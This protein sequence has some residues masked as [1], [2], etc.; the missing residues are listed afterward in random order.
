MPKAE[1]WRAGFG[2][3]KDIKRVG[4]RPKGNSAMRLA[5]QRH[6]FALSKPISIKERE[7][8]TIY[9]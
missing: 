8:L 2:K 9:L 5:H 6:S 1:F 7:T 3:G 4:G